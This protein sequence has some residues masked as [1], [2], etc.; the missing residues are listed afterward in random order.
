MEKYKKLYGKYGI[1]VDDSDCDNVIFYNEKTEKDLIKITEG[2]LDD[3]R[4]IVVEVY[5]DQEIFDYSKEWI[6]EDYF[7]N[8]KIDLYMIKE[9]FKNDFS[10][11]DLFNYI[12]SLF[13]LHSAVSKE[14]FKETLEDLHCYH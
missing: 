1:M 12:K 10:A 4:Y 6:I 13:E 9:T 2:C 7:E 5:A 11:I 3:T 14:E 8:P